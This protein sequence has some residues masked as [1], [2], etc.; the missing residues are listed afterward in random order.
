MKNKHGGF[1]SVMSAMMGAMISIVGA[2]IQFLMIYWILKAYGSSVNGFI[3][4]S[5]SLSLAAATAEGALGISTVILLMRPMANSD[6][7]SANEIISTAKTKYRKSIMTGVLVIALIS[8]LYPLEMAVVP[9]ILNGTPV[10]IPEIIATAP[11]VPGGIVKIQIWE[12][13]GIIWILGFKQIVTGSCFGI[14][15]NIIMADQKAGMKKIIILFA[16]IV[17][18]GALFLILNR[19]IDSHEFIHPIIPFLVLLMYGPIRG[20]MMKFYVKRYYTW[21]KY[22]PDFNNYALI[23]STNKMFWS[24]LGQDV[25]ANADMILLFVVLGTSGFK[26]TSSLS[27]YLLIGVNLRATLTSLIVSFREYYVSVL[28]KNGR[29]EWEAYSKYELYTFVIAAFA[30]IFMSMGA[31]YIVTGLYGQIVAG[32]FIATQFSTPMIAEK[33]AVEFIF[34]SPVFSGIY[35]ATISFILLFQGQTSLIQAKGKFGE[36]G[37]S[38]NIIAISFIATELLITFL[39]MTLT[40][41]E[42]VHYIVN[43]LKAFYI[44]KLTFMTINYIYLL[45]YTWRFVT[46]NSTIKYVFSNFLSLIFPVIASILVNIFV[47]SKQFPLVLFNESGAFVNVVTISI[48]LGIFLVVGIIGFISTLILPIILRPQV[49]LSMLMSLPIL[50]QIRQSAKDR[51][52]LKRYLEVEIHNLD[53]LKEQSELV[54]PELE[55]H[56]TKKKNVKK[57]DQFFEEYTSFDKPKIYKIKSRAK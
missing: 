9:S 37:K 57:N 45:Q 26:I 28:S 8:L 23:N 33:K 3:R 30:F 20:F 49:G 13:L 12:M 53:L 48:I 39:V 25:L 1:Q 55:I 41:A 14:Y 11:Q 31:P 54:N 56:K 6:W 50:K 2:I 7:I 29:L 24:N 4:I 18:Y 32:D 43:T 17:V 22:Y 36:V 46:Y 10:G 34:T 15:E 47:V 35:A 16:D 19:A 51:S 21:I 42:D 44:V 27:L 5:T 38:I 52:K 40:K